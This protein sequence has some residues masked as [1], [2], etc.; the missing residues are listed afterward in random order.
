MEM[1]K[2][3]VMLSVAVTVGISCAQKEPAMTSGLQDLQGKLAGVTDGDKEEGILLIKVTKDAQKGISEG[4]IESGRLACGIEDASVTPLFPVSTRKDI[5]AVKHG[6]DRWYEVRFDESVDLR[7]AAET[8]AANEAIQTIEYNTLIER[9]DSE[10]SVEAAETMLTRSSAPAS[11]LPFND[12]KLNVQWNLINT[13]DKTISETAMEGADVGVK[14]AWKLTAGDPRVIVAVFDQGVKYDHEDLAASMWVNQKEN[15]GNNGTDDDNNGYTDDIHGYNFADESHKLTYDTWL[16][17]GDHGTHVAGTIAATNNNGIG[18]SSVAGG[19]GNNDGVRIMSCQIFDKDGNK[20]GRNRVAKAFHYAAENGACIAQCSYG[21]DGRKFSAGMQVEDKFVSDA[22]F[23][24]RNGVEYEAL[25]F[26]LDPANANCPALETNIAVF[27]AGNYN[28]SASLFPGALKECISV[29]ATCPDFLPG[30]YSNYGA[31]CD[32]AAPG[33]DIVEGNNE[34]PQ[35]ILSTG[36]AGSDFTKS[37]AYIY[38]YGTSMA[39]PHVSGVVALGASYAL[40][41]G[42]KF[43]TEDFKSRLLTSAN[44]IDRHL[45]PDMKKLMVSGQEYVMADIFCKKGKMGTGAV[46][47]WK[48]LMELEGTPSFMTTPD[49]ELVINVADCIGETAGNFSYVLEIGQDTKEA[50]GIE[51]TPAVNEGILKITCKKI[52]AGKITFRSSVGKEGGFSGLDFH[53]EISVVCRPAVANNG[54]WL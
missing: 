36:C 21:E 38:K 26:F 23:E 24:K 44:D 27:S 54:G 14:D 29:T 32:I 3:I 12:P 8:L 43:S 41:I 31:G 50:L 45:Q 53:K 9:T 19:S 6:L 7:A 1:K 37:D 4:T 17:H 16:K 11:S 34:A 2:I 35:M 48:F 13:G 22:D 5:T 18:V 28:T 40:K 33:G 39:C 46:D 20:A 49:R 15:N 42:K 30:G 51:G 25:M 52:G 10:V 47:A